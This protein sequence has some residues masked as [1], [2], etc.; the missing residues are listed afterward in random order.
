MDKRELIA[1][2]LIKGQ[3]V[4]N[5]F[6][7]KNLDALRCTSSIVECL[8]RF[9]PE[10]DTETY[11]EKCLPQA[12]RIIQECAEKMYTIV[13]IGDADYPSSLFEI[14]DPP[15][16]LYMKGNQALL[17]NAIAVIGTRH[18]TSLG[19]KIAEKIGVYY[20]TSYSI[21]NGLAEGIDK[22][23]IY[24]NG[25]VLPNVI[26]VI[27][28]GLNFESTC[29]KSCA[30]IIKDVLAAGGLI[31]SE[32]PPYQKVDQFAGSKVS[33]VQAGLSKALILV[34][35]SM[36]GGSKYTLKAYSKLNRPLGIIHFPSHDEYSCDVF[37]A[38]R[39]IIEKGLNGVA[40]FLGLK[41]TK[42]L[43]FSKIMKIESV[44]DYPHLLAPDEMNDN[45]LF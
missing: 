25:S 28:G 39:A 16:V 4:G 19:E 11:A 2:T 35:S 14:G 27:S 22:H 17:G 18:S 34:Q 13:C 9:L 1:L 41:T 5:S 10:F 45:K 24:H 36:T 30:A 6:I 42:G 43:S 21:C 8:L 20:S 37:G 44:A 31:I 32:F 7:K 12:E 38:N 40:E 15:A 26:G 3:G 33:R 29:S 23:A